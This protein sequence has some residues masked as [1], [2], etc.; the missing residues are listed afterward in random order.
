MSWTEARDRQRA[1]VVEVQAGGPPV[2]FLVEHE[3]TVTLGRRGFGPC[4]APALDWLKG[5]GITPVVCE[6]GGGPT[7]HFPGQLVAYPILNVLRR[8]GGLRGYVAA[9][10]DV[11]IATAADFGVAA[12]RREGH[13]G[14]WVER[15]KLASGDAGGKL[16]SIGVAVSRG[17]AWHGLALNVGRDLSLFERVNPCGLP[18]VRATSLTLEARGAAVPEISLDEVKPVLVGH[19]HVRFPDLFSAD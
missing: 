14:A 3:P 12:G 13:P 15:R 17:V 18:G 4:V 2:L 5:Q 11:T 10:E 8:L 19:F 6:R 1:A 7:C 16:A 9:L